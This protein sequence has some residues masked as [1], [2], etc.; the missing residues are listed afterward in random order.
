MKKLLWACLL[1]LLVQASQA[2]LVNLA[3]DFKNLK[4]RNIG[5]A[6]MS[7]RVTAIDAVHSNPDIIYIGA[8]SG[9]VWKTTNGGASWTP[10][11]DDQPTQNIGAI[12]IQQSNPNVIWVGTGEGNPRNSVSLGEGM[13]K[14]IDGGKSWKLM[15]LQKTMNIHRILID[16][17]DP[18]TVYAG[19]IGNPFAAHP[20]RGVY[21]TTDGGDTW[22]L[23]LHTNDS[24]GVA[25]MVMDPSNPNKLLVCMW[26]H[27]RTPWSFFSGGKGSGF[28]STWDGG[29]NWKKLGKAEGLPDTT[30]RIGIAIAPSDPDVIYAMVEAT[31]N[32][33]YRSEDGGMKWTLVNSDPQW[34]TNRPFYFQDIMVDPQNENRLYNIY[35]MIAQSDDGGKSFRIIIPYDGVHP[36]HHA[37]WIHPKDPSFIINGNDGGIAISRDRGRSWQ[38]DEKLPLGQFYHINVDNE[39][40][41]NVMGGLQDNGSWHGPAY[42]WADGG[43]RNSY[44]KSVGGGDGFDVAPDPSDSKWVYSMSQGGN[45]GRMNI[46]T[47]ERW[48]I[49]PPMPD[50]NTRI[51]FNWNAALAQD[52]FDANTIYYGSQFVHKSTNK[53]AQWTIISGDLTTNDPAKQKQDENGG[54]T[55]DITN[56]ENHCTIV[57]IEPSKKEK[58]VLWVGTDDGQL[59]LTRD[60]GKTWTNLTA[61]IKGLPK[62]AWIPQIRTSRY[63]AGEVFVIANDYRRGDMGT[64]IFRSTD[65]GKTWVNMMAGKNNV[66]GYALCVL[67]DPVQPNLLFAGTENGLWVSFD[68]GNSFQQ[69]TN[70]YPSVSTYDLAIQEREADLVIATFGRALYILDDIRPLRAI[71]ANKG[72]LA[73]KKLSTYESPIAYQAFE[74]GPPGIEYSTYGL[75]AADNRGSDASINFFV[76]NDKAKPSKGNDSVTVKI[77]NAANEAIRTYKA[78]A[79]TGFN[80]IT[81]NFTTK[82]I[83]Q[84]GSPKPR[85]GAA[86]PGGGMRAAPGMYKA[87][88][89]MGDVADSSMLNVQYDPRV[90]FDEAV[91][92]AQKVMLQRLWQTSERLTAAMDRLTEMED[93][94][95]KLDG[96]LRDVEGKQADSLRKTNKAM[97]DSI[98]AIR[99]FINGKRQ[100]KQGYGTAYQLTVMTKLREP[101]MLIMGKRT[102]PGAQEEKALEVA[103]AMV[104]QAVDKVNALSNGAWKNYRQLAESTPIKLFNDLNDLK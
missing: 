12:A 2:Q 99:E 60:G 45:L 95:R 33:L 25:D 97:Q 30:G 49:R 40:P 71:A 64:Y 24:T 31:K 19:A 29:K 46:Q 52:P 102:L 7:G 70:N 53:G 82:G 1:L 9:G 14:S 10:I 100:E 39:I 62:G 63:N 57:A 101:Q 68:N 17:T 47:G 28:Y 16:P 15:G 93:I 42:V 27:N 59:Q 32:G 26:Q 80:R 35:Q 21:K 23:I 61:N 34:V 89:S 91:Y 51:R 67:Q 74:T 66:K 85:R 41:Y 8:A 72:M 50:P 73:D 13:Y 36:D 104:Q 11:F 18:N 75:Y 38:F 3:T 87:V 88:V 55:I 43:I 44:W 81:W 96:Q 20:E 86:E 103:A 92:N 98:K 77:Y 94:T 78:K 65:Y 56:A 37:W 5:P 48:S 83:R 22:K 58:D 84:P 79:D 6:G 76:K 4:A 90:K 69:F 54:L